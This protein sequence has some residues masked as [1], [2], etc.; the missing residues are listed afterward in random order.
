MRND[1]KVRPDSNIGKWIFIGGLLSFCGFILIRIF[2]GTNT[3][4]FIGAV[5]LSFSVLWS[6]ILII[7]TRN[8]Y[9]IVGFLMFAFLVTANLIRVFYSESTAEYFLLGVFVFGV[10][11]IYIAITKRVKPRVREILELAAKPVNGTANGFTAR[12]YVSGRAE[13]SGSEIKA[14]SKFLLKHLIALPY[15]ENNRTVILLEYS[16]KHVL[17]MRSDYS[18]FTHIIFNDDGQVL[19]SISRKYYLKYKKEL[20]FDQLCDSLGQ[21]F[22]EFLEMFIEGKG[23]RIIERMNAI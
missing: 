1:K 21:L 2:F 19:V 22:I 4:F 15:Y 8:W 6:F 23:D 13:F 20:T 11:W 17:N 5:L 3:T 10:W 14:F 16:Y 7:K 9:F 18:D 12:P